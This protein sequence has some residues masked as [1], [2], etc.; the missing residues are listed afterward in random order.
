MFSPKSYPVLSVDID[1][2]IFWYQHKPHQSNVNYIMVQKMNY[3]KFTW[4]VFSML[5]VDFKVHICC[6]ICKMGYTVG[7]CTGVTQLSIMHDILTLVNG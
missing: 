1:H 2:N 7:L 6:G 5:N 4:F 3:Y